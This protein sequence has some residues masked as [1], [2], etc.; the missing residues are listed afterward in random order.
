MTP[1]SPR[2]R[3]RGC[4]IAGCLAMLVIIFVGAAGSAIAA[5]AVFRLL[6]PQYQESLARRAAFLNDWMPTRVY[7]ADTLPTADS[8]R[9]AEAMALLATPISTALPLATFVPATLPAV[10]V[11][12]T[13]SP[14]APSP[15]SA[16]STPINPVQAVSAQLSVTASNVSSAANTIPLTPTLGMTAI[17]ATDLP[18]ATPSAV[19]TSMPTS[20]TVPAVFHLGGY[21]IVYQG[22]NNCGP[23]NLTQILNAYG[24]NTTQ[25]Q[26]AGY[27]KP[28]GADKNVS[29]WRIVQYV[30]THTTMRAIIRYGGNLTLIK[31][32]LNASF[33]PLIETG[34]VI[35]NNPKEGWMGHYLTPAGYDDTQSVFMGFDTYL[36]DGP[37]HR[38]NREDDT[39]L[40]TRWM[41][42]NR[43]YVVIY[44][45]DRESELM[46]LLG[47]DADPTEN[48]NNALNQ[49]KQV[50]TANPQD[51]FAWFDIG[52]TEVLLHNYQDAAAAYDQARNAG[53]GLPWRM[54]WYQ[55]GPLEAYT[56]IG[57]YKTALQLIATTLATTPDV[58][59]IFYWRGMVEALQ[60]NTKAAITDFH[61]TLNFNPNYIYAT[62]ALHAVQNS[63]TPTLPDVP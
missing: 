48:L 40:D 45:P 1:V 56:A 10:T 57:D 23:A 53:S 34:F 39:D 13:D 21:K 33:R 25:D 49:A 46:T 7:Q 24:V 37:D 28:S 63:Q 14:I 11:A 18:F 52:T 41:Q 30:Q 50:A 47:A 60:G 26:A 4:L 54:L 8:G 16:T 22:W 27:L 38:G 51:P 9:A 59:D 19:P 6:P 44:P 42:F 15:M 29:P 62:N 31:Q 36:G 61:N 55:F 32:L 43:V 2:P 58:E 20:V 12:P 35:P 17:T 5:P 3:R